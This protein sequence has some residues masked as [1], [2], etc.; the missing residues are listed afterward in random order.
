MGPAQ[1]QPL[2]ESLASAVE[3]MTGNGLS[4]TNAR[5]QL[6][7]AI[8]ERQLLI[9]FVGRPTMTIA[10]L[11][12][13][14]WQSLDCVKST[15]R[16]RRA[17][18]IPSWQA[19]SPPLVEGAIEITIADRRRLWPA[20]TILRAP[21]GKRGPRAIKKNRVIAQMRLQFGSSPDGLRELKEMKQESLADIFGC[22]RELAN[23][24]R[25]SVLSESQ[26]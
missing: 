9:F 7:Q 24:A 13:I 18:D 14:D 10:E 15:V 4:E 16:Y 8:M 6:I 23:E 20:T 19:L 2:R 1:F 25:K 17:V 22:G 5:Q 11:R 26:K 12:S 3:A 21:M